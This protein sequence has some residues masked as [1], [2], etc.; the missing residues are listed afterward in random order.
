[1]PINDDLT[2][3]V[4]SFINGVCSPLGAETH[5]FVP[6]SLLC[7]GAT[8]EAGKTQFGTGPFNGLDELVARYVDGLPD[9]HSADMPVLLTAVFKERGIAHGERNKG[10]SH[11]LNKEGVRVHFA[12]GGP[13]SRCLQPPFLRVRFLNPSAS[14]RDK[15]KVSSWWASHVAA[16]GDHITGRTLE[17]LEEVRSTIVVWQERCGRGVMAYG[18]TR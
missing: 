16:H 15:D 2:E 6:G 11:F 13:T 5:S 7:K 10:V 17:E 18:T 9:A 12:V 3:A 14:V 1:M 8:D 4:E